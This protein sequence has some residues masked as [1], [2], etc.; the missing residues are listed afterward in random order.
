MLQRI[1]VTNV[2]NIFYSLNCS[3]YILDF[4]NNFLRLF[5]KIAFCGGFG[6][7]WPIV[8]IYKLTHPQN[9]LFLEEQKEL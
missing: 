5:L 2:E 9:I 1:L 6:V 3:N 8:N 7:E 4:K